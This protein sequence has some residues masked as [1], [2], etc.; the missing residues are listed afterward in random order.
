MPPHTHMPPYTSTNTNTHI[1]YT[2]SHTHRPIPKAYIPQHT[3]ILSPSSLLNS[4]PAMMFP[5]L[6]PSSSFSSWAGLQFGPPRLP[7]SVRCP[8]QSFPLGTW[9]KGC[10]AGLPWTLLTSAAGIQPSWDEVPLKVGNLPGLEAD[11]LKRPPPP[12]NLS[13]EFQTLRSGSGGTQ[14]LFASTSLPSPGQVAH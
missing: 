6:P 12:L 4:V 10:P 5:G 1:C 8:R 14:C 3:Y 9:P 11:P 7:L 13:L 2:L